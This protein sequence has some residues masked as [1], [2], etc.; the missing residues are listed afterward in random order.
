M[1]NL[2]PDKLRSIIRLTLEQ[3][4]MYSAAA[5]ELLLGTAA[6]GSHL[7][8]RLMHYPDGSA[9]GLYQME[10]ATENDIWHKFLFRH[11]LVR[12]VSDLSGVAKPSIL[13]LQFNPIYSTAMAHLHY[14]RTK[15][16]LP[17]PNDLEALAD[18][19][20]RHWSRGAHD[21]SPARFI[22]DYR[23]FVLSPQ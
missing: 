3:M 14:H 12:L 22:R 15:D 19:W 6:H 17:S 11:D 23:R 20:A 21:D 9:R 4:D 16:P 10:P 2:H 13:N 8:L 18:Y 5:E 7:G 1:A